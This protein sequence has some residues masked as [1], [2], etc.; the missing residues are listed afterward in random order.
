MFTQQGF[1]ESLV[2][3]IV[4]TDQPFTVV[5]T[6]SFKEMIKLCNKNAAIPS[7]DTVK[8]DI[9]EMFKQKR[10]VLRTKLHDFDCRMSFTLDGWTTPNNKAFLG[11]TIHYIDNNWT[12]QDILMDVVELSGPHSGENL[13][14]A[15]EKSAEELCVLTKML[16]ITCDN[17]ANNDVLLQKLEDHCKLNNIEF[18]AKW[19][20]VR[21]I[22]HIM[23]LAVQA[24]LKAVKIGKPQE[25]EELLEEIENEKGGVAIKDVASKLR[26]V[27]VKI[28][29]SP[30]RSRRFAQQCEIAGLPVKN[31]I[32]D[33][34]TRWNSTFHMMERANELQPAL[35]SIIAIEK[36][37][38]IYALTEIEWENIQDLISLLKIFERATKM[39]SS[40][41]YPNLSASIPIYDWL[42]DKLED[43]QKDDRTTEELH[44]AIQ[45][46]L[47]KIKYYY[48]RSDDCHMYPIST[49]LDP[50]LKLEYYREHNWDKRWIEESVKVLTRI[51]EKD[52]SVL[53]ADTSES[54]DEED[55]CHHLYKRRRSVKET[56]LDIYLNTPIVHHKTDVL[57]WWRLHEQD[58]PHLARMARDFLAIPATSIPVERVFS[59]GK[60]I[61]RAK[62]SSLAV[63]T[64]SACMCLKNW[65]TRF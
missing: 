48:Q 61:V 18:N 64:I 7:A 27:I 39:V 62:R 2:H 55:L 36:D 41:K 53:I 19:N 11:I 33:I 43:F 40:S 65:S 16:A 37:L 45:E 9:L 32:L 12:L 20:H 46:G 6:D 38:R 14:D 58:F 60:D 56:E 23:N 59:S 25:E 10:D 49:I 52:Y 3:W 4:S 50:R 5:E 17:A 28:R 35:E 31:L 63:E 34:K 8:G 21:C 26:K 15:F 47:D 29:S 44:N 24:I 22:A 30:Q 13:S 54:S 42:M 57:Q 51:Y 1:R